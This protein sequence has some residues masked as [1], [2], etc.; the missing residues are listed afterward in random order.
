MAPVRL[1]PSLALK[2]CSDRVC[3]GCSDVVALIARV[4]SEQDRLVAVEAHG[5]TPTRRALA[6]IPL[7]EAINQTKTKKK[8]ADELLRPLT[9]AQR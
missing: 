8:R 5:T 1:A 4:P 3:A 2:L 9:L 7:S 6:A